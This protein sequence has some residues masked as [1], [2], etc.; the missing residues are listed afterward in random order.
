MYSKIGKCSNRVKISTDK[1]Y[2][3]LQF[4]SALSKQLYGK[5]QFFK[6]LGRQ[7][8]AENRKW[9]ESLAA[10]I[11]ADIDHPDVETLF[12]PSLKKYLGIKVENV[13]LHPTSTT[14]KLQELW[15]EFCD[16]KYKTG[17]ISETTYK[18]KYTRT[19]SNWLRPYF[20]EYISQELA[21]R[22]VFELQKQKVNKT[23]LRKMISALK[24]ACDRSIN[25]GN[26]NRNYFA[27]LKENIKPPKRSKQLI[28]EEDYRAFTREER[29]IIINTFK[30]SHKDSERQIAPLV[31]FLFLTGCRLGEA[32]AFK[33]KDIKPK[34][35]W[36][37]FD[38]S[39][40][41]ETKITKSTKT[42]V[43]R[44]FK[45]QGYTRLINLLDRMK[46]QNF[47]ADD[48]VFTT[49]GGKQYNRLN[50]SA[51]WL[52]LDKSKKGNKYYYPGVV[53]RLVQDGEINQYLKPSA[54][55]HTF[56]TIQAHA[57]VD[58]KLLAD[59]VGNSVDVIYDHYLGVNK[60]AAFF[61]I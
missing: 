36:I 42:D 53:T 61:D 41:S 48:Y 34:K 60:D 10:R 20:E 30:T 32:F 57:G 13:I 54:T 6:S 5:R 19:F 3:R 38:E 25:Q 4:P 45:I 44:I 29:D 1:D 49:L 50:L 12:D 39:Y 58:L 33:W 27:G 2:L 51:L 35:G 21:E 47:D 17:K 43:I 9:A 31:E 22:I 18:T 15:N 14:I 24:E 26:L 37:V 40:S 59:S 52:G 11:Q 7:D 46:T 23:N 8:T 56:I 28:E 55:R 16:Y